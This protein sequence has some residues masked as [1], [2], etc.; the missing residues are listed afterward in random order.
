MG[1][2]AEMTETPN[3]GNSSEWV[4]TSGSFA[5]S[6]GKFP[7]FSLPFLPN[8]YVVS[9]GLTAQIGFRVAAVPEPGTIALAGAGLAGLAGIEW[10]RRRKAKGLMARG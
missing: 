4:A 6:L 10:T 7:N 2:I 3:S 1:N 5:T 8:T 9:T